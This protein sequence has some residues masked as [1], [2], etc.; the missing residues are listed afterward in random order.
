M[1][2]VAE[3]AGFSGFCD[4]T[5]RLTDL[6]LSPGEFRAV[7]DTCRLRESLETVVQDESPRDLKWFMDDAAR[8]P[9]YPCDTN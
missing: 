3:M 2:N 4:G 8:F 9:A 5:V 1:L 6:I 7:A